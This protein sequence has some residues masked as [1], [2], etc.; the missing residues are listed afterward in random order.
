MFS[1]Q[2]LNEQK[3]KFRNFIC[4][5]RYYQQFLSEYCCY[6]AQGLSIKIQESDVCNVVSIC[7][8]FQQS[9]SQKYAMFEWQ[10]D[11]RQS[12]QKLHFLIL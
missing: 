8:Q 3:P 11:T 10:V 9:E 5:L 12:E 4:T 7:V 6:W 2:K 1:Q